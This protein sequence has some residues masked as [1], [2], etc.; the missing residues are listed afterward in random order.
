[1]KFFKAIASGIRQRSGSTKESKTFRDDPANRYIKRSD[2]Y[3]YEW[4]NDGRGGYDQILPPS[5]QDELNDDRRPQM[6]TE[7][8]WG[9]R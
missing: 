8:P 9:N 6:Y 4:I 3:W 5:K 1:M 7:D 2:G